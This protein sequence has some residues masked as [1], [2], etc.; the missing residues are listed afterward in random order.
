MDIKYFFLVRIYTNMNI[1]K[2]SP[3]KCSVKKVFLENSQI[4][5]ENTC[6]RVSFLINLQVLGL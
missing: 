2:Q 5:Q 4:L 1:Q 6:G 3:R